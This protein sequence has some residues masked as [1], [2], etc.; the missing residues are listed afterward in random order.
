MLERKIKKDLS[1]KKVNLS[2]NDKF[3]FNEYCYFWVD[4]VGF[5]KKIDLN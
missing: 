4:S 1:I 5:Y 2:K 3:T